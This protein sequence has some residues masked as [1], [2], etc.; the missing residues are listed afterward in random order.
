MKRE[1]KM[2]E[3]VF[4]KIEKVDERLSK[5]KKKHHTQ[6]LLAVVVMY[7]LH[8]SVIQHEKEIIKLKKAIKELQSKGE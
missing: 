3:L 2:I 5:F 4:D 7:A 6:I 1:V 8:K